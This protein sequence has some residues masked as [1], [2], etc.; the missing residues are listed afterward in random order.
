MD[1]IRI[2]LPE[3]RRARLRRQGGNNEISRQSDRRHPVSRRPCSATRLRDLK[4]SHSMRTNRR[5]IAIIRRSWCDSLLT[6]SQMDGVFGSD[7]HLVGWL[8]R[9]GTA[10]NRLPAPSRQRARSPKHG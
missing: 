5:P 8:G 2:I 1:T 3:C 6:A 4:Q 9:P 7:N 10:G